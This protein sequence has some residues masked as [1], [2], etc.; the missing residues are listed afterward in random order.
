MNCA[1]AAVALLVSSSFGLGLA[2]TPLGVG[3]PV[4]PGT[5]GWQGYGGNSQHNGEWLWGSDSL[6]EILWYASLDDDRSYYGEYVLAH[7]ASPCITPE[8]TLI[9]SHRFTTDVEGSQNYDNWQV[10]GR[11]AKTGAGIWQFYTDYEAPLVW[12]SDWTTV[13]PM[14]L[15][16]GSTIVAAGGGGTVLERNGDAPQTIPFTRVS[17][18]SKLANYSSSPISYAK[19]KVCTPITGSE[20]GD[21]WFGYLVSGPIPAPVSERLGTGGLVHID[22]LGNPTFVKVSNLGVDPALQRPALNAAPALSLDGKYVY[23]AI[24]DA[25]TYDAYLVKLNASTLQLVDSVRLLDPSMVGSGAGTINESSASPSVGPDGHVFYGVFG[26]TY[27]ESHGW[28]LQFDENLNPNDPSGNR[29]PEGSFGWDT[30]ASVVPSSAVPTYKGKA[31]YL[32]LTKYNN[33]DIGDGDGVN[34]V[35]IL[36]PTSNGVSTDR[37]SG[38]PVM[39]EILTVVGPTPDPAP[40]YPNAVCEWCINSAAVDVLNKSAIVNSEDGHV[41]RWSFVTNTLTQ[42][43]NLQPATGEAYTCTCIGPDGKVYAVNNTYL[44]ACGTSGNSGGIGPAQPLG[45]VSGK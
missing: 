41:Y 16:G 15:T 10:V 19:I 14:S 32:V 11:S 13:F 20:A 1:R 44:F 29:W 21:I 8:D 2:S 18:Y 5:A 12:P 22:P 9:H 37:Q 6:K 45:V 34:K 24:C 4:A 36:D 25:S 38:I 35:A 26:A 33:Y 42:P 31:S 40:G 17:F 27:R 7:Y 39:N 3:N 23:F 30:T 28:L 43:L